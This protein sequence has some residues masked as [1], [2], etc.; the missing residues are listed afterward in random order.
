MYMFVSGIRMIEHK[1]IC[2]FYQGEKLRLL[3][4]KQ[5]IVVDLVSSTIKCGQMF[6][7]I[8]S[9]DIWARNIS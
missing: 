5:A 4:M 9:H 2:I 1:C 8:G 6:C 3:L 7:F